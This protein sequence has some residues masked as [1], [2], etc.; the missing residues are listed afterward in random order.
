MKHLQIE[1]CVRL[2]EVRKRPGI[3]LSL[4][5]SEGASSCGHLDFG[6]LASGWRHET[7]KGA[8]LSHP[9]RDTLLQ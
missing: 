9:L 3:P 8:A 1:E 6:L 5:S 2:S 7:I 4:V